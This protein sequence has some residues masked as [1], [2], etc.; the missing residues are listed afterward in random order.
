[1]LE[2]NAINAPNLQGVLKDLDIEIEIEK[3]S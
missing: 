3:V 2:K 1:V